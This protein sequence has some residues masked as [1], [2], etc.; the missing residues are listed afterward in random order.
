MG[1]RLLR[2]CGRHPSERTDV[3]G[4][5]TWRHDVGGRSFGRS[6]NSSIVW[7]DG[8]AGER[9]LEEGGGG[10]ACELLTWF[11][12]NGTTTASGRFSSVDPVLGDPHQPRAG[13]DMRM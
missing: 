8:G 4:L 12:F 1:A 11:T 7:G 9:K 3:D 2:E 6:P 13:T 5:G 10:K